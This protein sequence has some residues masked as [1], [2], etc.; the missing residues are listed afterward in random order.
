MDL[1]DGLYEQIIDSI[2]SE[3]LKELSREKYSVNKIEPAESKKILSSYLSEILEEGLSALV[4]K[5]KD[6]ALETQVA[7]CNELIRHISEKVNDDRLLHYEIENSSERLFLVNKSGSLKKEDRPETP[8]SI[9]SLF[10]GSRTD[11]QMGNELKREILTSDRIDIIVSFIRWSGLRLIFEELKEFTKR[12]KLRVM[13]TTYMGAT[14]T[15]AVC[16]LAKLTNTEVKIAYNVG[17]TRLHAKSY[18]F[19]RDSGFNVAYV[20]SSNLSSVAITEGREWNVK[21]TS[22]D[23]PHIFDN[24][25]ATF[26]TYWNSTDF[27]KFDQSDEEKLSK[28]LDDEKNSGKST[29]T[30]EIKYVIDATPYSFQKDILD[31]LDAERKIHGRFR[32]LVVAATGT[33]KTVI[34]AFDYKRFCEENPGKNNSLLF[35]AHREDIL[36]QSLATFRSILKDGNFGELF[37]G[38]YKPKNTDHLFMSIQTF[39]SKEF[40][41]LTYPDDYDFIIV[42]ETHHS[43]AKSY[44]QIFTYY[45][46]KILLG[47][48]A[49]PERMD[50]IDITEYFDNK[51]A[52]EIRLGE[53]IDRGFLVPF[54]YFCVPDNVDLSGMKFVNGKYD[55]R[56]LS[57]FY[58]G[59]KNRAILVL[60]T[61]EKY[62]SILDDIKALGFCVT[63]EHAHFMAE[64]FNANGL[65]S[66]ALSADSTQEERKTAKIKLINGEVKVIFT[67][68]LYNEGVD[69][70]QVNTVLFLRPTEST[71]VF[72]QQLGRGLRTYYG[73][74]ELTVFDFISQAHK[75]YNYSK[76][77]EA[78]T[79]VCAKT[80]EAQ[81]ISGFPSLPVG[82]YIQMESVAKEYILNNIKLNKTNRSKLIDAA[83]DYAFVTGKKITLSGFLEY[84]S[85]SSQDLYSM[86]SFSKLCELA[87]L[88]NEKIAEEDDEFFRKGLLNILC[89][90]S[91]RW[92]SL[93]REII[94]KDNK[95]FS[96]EQKKAALMLFYSFYT[97]GLREAGFNE[98]SEFISKMKSSKFRNE[99]IEVLDYMY[100]KIDF[101]D[102]GI[103]LGFDNLVDLHCSYTRNQLLA[104]L[105]ISDENLRPLREGVLFFK[106]KNTDIFLVTL[107]KTEKEFS[108]TTMYEDYALS[109][110]LFHWQSQSGT[111]PE[112]PTGMRYRS[113]KESKHNI[114]LFVRETNYIKG[115][116]LPYVYLGK[117]NFIS[118]KGSRPMSI[119]W[120]L[121]EPMP[122][123]V[124]EI[125]KIVNS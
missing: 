49:T 29:K 80:I 118:F 3:K 50:G 21:I 91:R 40:H 113:Q 108:P 95:V 87:E 42:D 88:S 82:C 63:I 96:S 73:K 44:H 123:W 103:D 22:K 13:T 33:G 75:K 56:E 7:F 64:V 93:I 57:D 119:V 92:I 5:N 31:K 109:D 4:D 124:L 120:E 25:T 125:S 107:R 90:N 65:P 11:P 70:P 67:V 100:E 2:T 76:K 115:K 71:T 39:V 105:G 85:I 114:L 78:L 72:I 59:N 101:I 99:L 30:T 55:T 19:H 81:I 116:T 122:P 83:R 9:S 26:D 34:S 86:F 98:I 36:T 12:G 111:S 8:L 17:N 16:E 106:E 60:R 14:E 35:I 121:E 94:T 69:I 51:I 110:K 89:M 41:K 45:S 27:L 74:T 52:A 28:A 15:K 104:G 24:L 58:V 48:T 66:I 38:N 84:Y 54:Q 46:P 61:I 18:I 117:V 6:T 1:K 77:F 53:A 10:T 20:G 32:N 43:A 23:L 102:K 79:A 112:S 68:D 62:S 97:T 47:H 37:T